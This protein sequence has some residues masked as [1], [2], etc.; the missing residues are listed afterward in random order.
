VK[1]A[2]HRKMRMFIRK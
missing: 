1:P 2:N